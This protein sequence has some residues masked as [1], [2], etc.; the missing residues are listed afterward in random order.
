[1]ILRYSSHPPWISFEVVLHRFQPGNF[2]PQFRTENFGVTFQ[3]WSNYT[4]YKQLIASVLNLFALIRKDCEHFNQFSMSSLSENCVFK[5]KS[6]SRDETTKRHFLKVVW[7]V[8]SLS[9]SCEKRFSCIPCYLSAAPSVSCGKE[10]GDVPKGAICNR[11]T[12]LKETAA[13]FIKF[14]QATKR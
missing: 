2:S 14:H 3:N 4:T 8:I 6:E 12:A 10:S 11:L 7:V 5:I 1:M 9:F 13:L